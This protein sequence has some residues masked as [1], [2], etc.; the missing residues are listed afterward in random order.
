MALGPYFGYSASFTTLLVGVTIAVWTVGSRVAVAFALF[1]Y[2]A[3]HYLFVDPRYELSF[4]DART[5]TGIGAYALTCGLII[6]IGEAMRSAQD[7]AQARGELL[8]VAL[9]G[10]DDAVIATDIE[11]RITYLNDSAEV[12]TGWSCTEAMGH[13]LDTVFRLTEGAGDDGIVNELTRLS[14]ARRAVLLGRDGVARP[15]EQSMA[16]IKDSDGQIAGCVVAFRDIAQKQRLERKDGERVRT[17]GLLAAIVASCDDAIVSNSLDGIVRTWSDGAERL[18]GYAPAEMIGAHIERII[19]SD[20]REKEH[21]LIDAALKAGERVEHLETERVH[22]SG[23]RIPVCVTISPILDE[24]GKVIGAAKIARDMTPQSAIAQRER[25]LLREVA[26]AN[27]RSRALDEEVRTLAAELSDAD[28]RRNVF[29]ATL[30]RALHAQLERLRNALEN[31]KWAGADRWVTVTAIEKIEA[32]TTDIVRLVDD[33]RDLSAHDERTL[34]TNAIGRVSAEPG[35]P[36][37]DTP[38]PATARVQTLSRRVLVVDDDH[39]CARSLARL[40]KLDGHLTFVAHGGPEALDAAER[41]H[42]EVV[43]LDLGMPVMDGYE[44]CRRLRERHGKDL[45]IVA[46]TAWGRASDRRKSQEAGFDG[47]FVKPANYGALAA[48]LESVAGQAPPE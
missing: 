22:K 23:R 46:L 3:C 43:F 35:S 30:A 11:S 12:L 25:L 47:H 20:R 10:V 41:H 26:G 4:S 31:A 44:V 34:G 13:P 19:P 17:A 16:P 32:Q 8:R 33:L 14:G 28:R 42:P 21:A 29:L 5:L 1:G 7:R 39:G 36:Q 6:A 38:I 40:L 2:L 45:V 24:A 48:V 15:I 27:E 18:L 37:Q 9:A